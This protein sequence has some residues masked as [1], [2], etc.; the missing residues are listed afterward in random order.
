MINFTN[1][2]LQNNC[3]SIELAE[4]NS[5]FPMTAPVFDIR[6]WG[7]SETTP[8]AYCQQWTAIRGATCITH[9]KWQAE[10]YSASFSPFI[11]ETAKGPNS[12]A[13]RPP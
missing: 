6:I 8:G 11:W 13:Q 3:G 5:K 9:K 12:P 2:L 7:M 1:E 4:Q 10:T